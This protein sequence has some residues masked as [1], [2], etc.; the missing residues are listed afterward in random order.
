MKRVT[1]VHAGQ[2]S[3]HVGLNEGHENF[4]TVHHGHAKHGKRG[5]GHQRCECGENFD[6][7]VSGCHVACQTNGMADRT[8]KVGNNFD[9]GQNRADRQRC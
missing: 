2:N 7:G 8:D 5:N 6:H 1:K 4:E 9:Q 3:E